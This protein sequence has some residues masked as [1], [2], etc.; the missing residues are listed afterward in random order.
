MTNSVSN[1]V[2]KNP[3]SGILYLSFT[4]MTRGPV[5]HCSETPCLRLCSGCFCP[6]GCVSF[7]EFTV[8]EDSPGRGNLAK[9]DKTRHKEQR[10]CSFCCFLLLRNS[11]FKAV[12]W[13]NCQ[14]WLKQLKQLLTAVLAR[15]GHFWWNRPL[16]TEF[17][18][19]KARMAS[20]PFCSI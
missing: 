3:Y 17:P 20:R 2:A 16:N 15:F 19:P 14:K 11:V 9:T 18:G 6:F 1:Q 5:F 10:S 7:T 4:E 12:F 13:L 8:R